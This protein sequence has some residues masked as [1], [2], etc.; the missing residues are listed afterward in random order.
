MTHRQQDDWF[1]RMVQTFT[2]QLLAIAGRRVGAMSDDIVQSVWEVAI[3][4]QARLKD[5]E[6][7]FQG[8]F[9]RCTTMLILG[10]HYR[11]Q[12]RRLSN[13]ERARE[14]VQL[15]AF[16]S[17]TRLLATELAVLLVTAFGRLG[18]PDQVIIK[19]MCVTG[20]SYKELATEMNISEATLRQNLRRALVRLRVHFIAVAGPVALDEFDT[21]TLDLLLSTR[22][23]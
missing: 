20:T 11:A 13:E 15:N 18:N 1:M 4:N 21:D 5:T 17:E 3:H 9:L 14:R 19:A 8:R 6:L 16:R 10:H 23:A 22:L 7:A 12:Q 2:P